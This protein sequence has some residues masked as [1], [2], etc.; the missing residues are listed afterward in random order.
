[1]KN[2]GELEKRLKSL[3]K[4][5]KRAIT[6][7]GPHP[8]HGMDIPPQALRQVTQM[9]SSGRNTPFYE[10]TARGGGSGGSS[11]G[12]AQQQVRRR[13]QGGQQQYYGSG[14]A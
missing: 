1:M 11:R 14:Y 6:T 5:Q 10:Q 3:F 4:K 7:S 8:H 9:S 13:P 12:G 2:S